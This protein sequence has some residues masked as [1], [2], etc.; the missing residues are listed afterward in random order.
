MDES[1]GI[2][3]FKVQYTSG[4]KDAIVREINGVLDELDILYKDI[5]GEW[6]TVKSKFTLDSSIKQKLN[7][8]GSADGNSTMSEEF[9][10]VTENFRNLITSLEAID[11]SWET[12][13][14][15]IGTAIDKYSES[16]KPENQ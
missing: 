9:S 11:S 7:N 4:Q 1:S 3:K 6:E 15:D 5:M 8:I 12:V 14:Q 10:K 13:A 16:G 2:N